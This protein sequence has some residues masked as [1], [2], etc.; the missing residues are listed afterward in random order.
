[1]RRDEEPG[2]PYAAER[3]GLIS[4]TH[5]LLRS[6]V[7]PLFEGAT[8]ILHA[9]DV[10]GMHVLDELACIAP[11]ITVRGNT[12]RGEWRVGLPEIAYVEWSGLGLVLVHRLSDWEDGALLEHP[13]T[14]RRTD[15]VVFGH[16][17]KAEITWR[18]GCLYVNPGSA[19]PKRYGLVSTA[20][21]LFVDDRGRPRAQ[22]VSLEE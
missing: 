4:D 2:G 14:G 8:R 10:G 16:S 1:V 15:V 19:G 17:H 13:G 7:R 12:D 20:A 6:C 5:G 11:V 3:L 22:V 21:L 18:G 9:G